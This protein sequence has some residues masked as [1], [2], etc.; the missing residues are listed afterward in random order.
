MILDR[1]FILHCSFSVE[2]GVTRNSTDYPEPPDRE[3]EHKDSPHVRP[4]R[5]IKQPVYYTQE[6]GKEA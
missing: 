5:I 4:K 3:V 1:G 2:E 6:Q